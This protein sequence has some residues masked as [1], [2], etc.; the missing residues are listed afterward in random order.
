MISINGGFS[1]ADFKKSA[2]CLSYVWA[3]RRRHVELVGPHE[4]SFK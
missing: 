4:Q 2:P 1:G 3:V